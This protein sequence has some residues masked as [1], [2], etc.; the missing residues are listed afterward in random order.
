MKP[1]ESAY[2]NA[3]L[4][5]ASYVSVSSNFVGSQLQDALEKRMTLTQAAFI[6]ANFDVLDSVETPGVSD[7]T[8][9]DAVVW[10]GI[11][12]Y[13]NSFQDAAIRTAQL[14]A[15][16]NLNGIHSCC[17]PACCYVE[18]NPQLL[19]NALSGKA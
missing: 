9:F 4:A 8:G 16:L 5:D 2:I 18:K 3:L 7:S 11:H 15:D 19:S 17:R 14:W 12:G 6:A 1:I 13:N 10:R